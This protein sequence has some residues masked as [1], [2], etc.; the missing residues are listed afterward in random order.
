MN[1]VEAQAYLDTSG[2]FLDISF[3]NSYPFPKIAVAIWRE[4]VGRLWIPI[5]GAARLFVGFY[6]HLL[7]KADGSS[8]HTVLVYSQAFSIILVERL[9]KINCEAIFNILSL[10]IKVNEKSLLA[11]SGVP[12]TGNNRNHKGLLYHEAYARFTC[13]HS[14][15]CCLY[16][17]AKRN[18]KRNVFHSYV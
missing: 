8:C 18:F 5:E 4:A 13:R 11:V 3:Q 10:K 16:P 1:F 7:T 9:L 17:Y 2:V 6:F 12:Q 14:K 15:L